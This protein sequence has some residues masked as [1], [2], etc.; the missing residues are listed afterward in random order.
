MQASLRFETENAEKLEKVVSISLESKGQTEY[1]TGVEGDELT[2][3]ISTR[4]LGALRGSTDTAFRLMS[5]AE[6]LY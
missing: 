4:R 6:K 1:K 5:L 2:I 3:D